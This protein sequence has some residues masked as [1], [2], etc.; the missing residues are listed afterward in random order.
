MTKFDPKNEKI[1][2][3]MDKIWQKNDKIWQKM[4]KFD[5]KWQIFIFSPLLVFL[6]MISIFLSFPFD[7]PRKSK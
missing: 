4:K 5:K 6:A 1:W 3:K 7:H 2:Q